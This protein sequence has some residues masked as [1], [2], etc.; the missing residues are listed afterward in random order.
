MVRESVSHWLR[1]YGTTNRK[2]K[3]KDFFV[4]LGEGAIFYMSRSK[5]HMSSNQSNSLVGSIIISPIIHRNE[6]IQST[7][8]GE[9][10][11]YRVA[12]KGRLG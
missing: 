12:Q 7:H 1:V 8:T 4:L 5:T 11:K 10:Y 9:E 6:S 2:G 3:N